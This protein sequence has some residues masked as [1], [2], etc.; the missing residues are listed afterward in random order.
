MSSET[1]SNNIRAPFLVH[2]AARL[3]LTLAI[4]IAGGFAASAIRMPLAWMLGPFIFCAIGCMAGLPLKA[5]PHGREVGQIVVGLSVGMRFTGAVLAAAFALLPAM[6]ASTLFIILVTFLAAFILMPL[7]RVDRTTAFFATAAAGMAD[8]AAIAEHRGGNPSAVAVVHAVRVSLVVLTVPLLVYAFGEHGNVVHTPHAARDNLLLLAAVLVAAYG[9]ARLVGLTHFPN[10]WLIGGLLFGGLV[11]VT[12]F[13]VVSIPRLLMI[14]SQLA[15]GLSLGA[16]FE[17][18]LILRLPRVAFGAV[19]VTVF[20]ILAAA[21]GAWLLSAWVGLPYSVGF[22]SVAP[23]A[24][25]EMALTAQAM[26][27]DAQIVTAFHVMRIALVEASILL[28]YAVFRK[29]AP[30]GS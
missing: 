30:E 21:A 15:I 17:R 11:G 22:L 6:L 12:E 1:R 19:V 27:V 5:I 7:A 20:L 13:A 25:T 14:A 4:G 24:V 29:L 10:C 2:P 3:A 28:V 9:A 23:A 16:R 18:D 26:N 8:M